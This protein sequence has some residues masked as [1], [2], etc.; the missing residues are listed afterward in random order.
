MG[1]SY[2]HTAFVC[3]GDT[4][5]VSDRGIWIA[6][7]GASC[8]MTHDCSNMYDIRSP[9]PGREAIVIGHGRRLRGLCVGSV[10]VI[11]YGHTE[12]RYTLFYVS[13]VPGLGFNLYSLHAIQRTYVVVQGTAGTHKIGTGLAFPR[14]TKGSCVRGSRLPPRS[15][16]KHARQHNVYASNLLRQLHHPVPPFHQVSLSS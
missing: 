12:V 14:G 3:Q 10:D 11:F 9:P 15:I 7:S 4:S 16:T 13:Y 6:D 1:S 2:L 8:H 5:G